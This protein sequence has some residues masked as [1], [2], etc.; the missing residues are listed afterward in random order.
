MKTKYILTLF[1]LFLIPEL[2]SQTTTI[3]LMPIRIKIIDT[4]QAVL[5]P[6]QP[7]PLF[8]GNEKPLKDIQDQYLPLL[9]ESL[10]NFFASEG[11][12]TSKLNLSNLTVEE[13]QKE[14]EL[15]IQARNE[16]YMVYYA[17]KGLIKMKGAKNAQKGVKTG[18][19]ANIFADKLDKDY[20]L[21]T[22]IY[23]CSLDEKTYKKKGWIYG[24]LNFYGWIMDANSGEILDDIVLQFPKKIST[25]AYGGGANSLISDKKIAVWTEKFAKK[26]KMKMDKISNN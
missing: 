16:Y 13:R 26:L 5:A 10:D 9:S 23:G 14:E 3:G 6:M 22:S 17:A 20:L 12:K 25:T 1:A 7:N 18:P 4:D 19:L 21:F 8:G 15:Y 24:K 11:I 2:F